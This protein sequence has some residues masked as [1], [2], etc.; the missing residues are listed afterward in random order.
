MVSTLLVESHNL[1]SVIF[2]RDSDRFKN[3]LARTSPELQA[4]VI[5]KK[6]KEEVKE[7]TIVQKNT[8][9]IVYNKLNEDSLLAAAIYKK[10]LLDNDIEP[11][12]VDITEQTV[13]TCD[14]I[15]WLGTSPEDFPSLHKQLSKLKNEVFL[16]DLFEKEFSILNLFK[17]R[18]QNFHSGSINGEEQF[19][20]MSRYKVTNSVIEHLDLSEY[21][22]FV[23]RLTRY[24]ST[25]K[26]TLDEA[27]NI[28][29]NLK[30][31]YKYLTS[32]TEFT[33][34]SLTETQLNPFH[35]KDYVK[36]YKE[37]KEKLKTKMSCVLISSSKKHYVLYSNFNDIEFL[38]VKRLLTLAGK[39]YI[40]HSYGLVGHFIES[41]MTA[42]TP[43]EIK[44][45]IKN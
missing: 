23:L 18:K 42:M 35:V 21:K 13:F 8:H 29:F 32:N 14:A 10:Y 9:C 24:Y 43:K 1:P 12:M 20:Q 27:A 40:N 38:L 7:V 22:G 17:S 28:W 11:S 39:K 33:L 15:I 44:A 41:N 30:S 4:S 36:A 34:T 2:K 25:E 19:G 26:I 31:I 6:E 5:L 37:V 3:V 45:Q 16:G